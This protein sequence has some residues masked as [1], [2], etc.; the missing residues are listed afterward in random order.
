MQQVSLP[1]FTLIVKNL[2][3]NNTQLAL[4]LLPKAQVTNSPPKCSKPKVRLLINVKRK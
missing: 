3:K 1:S 4:N 2:T